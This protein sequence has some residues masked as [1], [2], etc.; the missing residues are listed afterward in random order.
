MCKNYENDVKINKLFINRRVCV[1][2]VPFF[3]IAA[4][5]W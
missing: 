2:F 3:K 5:L 1:R 4:L